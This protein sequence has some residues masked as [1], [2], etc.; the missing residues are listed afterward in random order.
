MNEQTDLSRGD[1]VDFRVG[2]WVVRPA[3]GVI[4]SAAGEV[5]L[6]PRVMQLLVYLAER[7]GT[8]VSA[9][10]LLIDVWRGAFYG[11]NPVH[12]CVAM[13]RRALADSAQSPRYLQTLR[14]RGY[15]LIAPVSLPQDH[16]PD[17]QQG[18][19]RPWRGECPFVGLRAFSSAE[20]ALYFGRSRA[21]AGLLAAVREQLR[22]GRNLLLV[23][24]PSG[25]GKSSLLRAGVLPRLCHAQGHDG[26]RVG[27]VSWIDLSR[28]ALDRDDCLAR[29]RA[30]REPGPPAGAPVTADALVIDHLET[31]ASAAT[32]EV[33]RQQ[34][35]ALLRELSEQPRLLLFLLA[36]SDAYSALLQTL[37][38]LLE[39][40]A[41]GGQ[42][43][44]PPVGRGEVAEMIRGPA[45]LA[46]LRFEVDPQTRVRLDDAL[47]DAAAGHPA[48]LPLL[49]YTLQQLYDRREPDGTL[50]FAAYRQIGGLT[51][52]IASRAEA[53]FQSLSPGIQAAL[54]GVLTKLVRLDAADDLLT[55][56]SVDRERLG[57]INE[58]AL[59][60]ALVDARLLTADHWQGRPTISLAHDALLREWPRAHA[61]AQDNRRLISARQRLAEAT[62]RWQ[63]AGEHPDHL[64]PDGAPL[65]QAQSVAAQIPAS[66]RREER[67]FLHL[68]SRRGRQRQRL[69]WGAVGALLL[70][71]I[72]AGVFAWDATRARQVAEQRRLEGET[73]VDFLLDDLS[74]RLR[75]IGRLDLLGSVTQQVT[76][77]L[78]QAGAPASAQQA[79]RRARALRNLAEVDAG[80]GQ[81]QTASEA[82]QAALRL[83][84]AVDPAE[85]DNDAYDLEAG[86][87]HY[88]HGFL[89]LQAADPIAAMAAWQAYHAAAE[90]M[91]QR[92][93]KSPLAQLELSYALNNLGNLALRER[94][95]D[96]AATKFERSIQL[97]R[98][99]HLREPGRND[100]AADL[101]DSLS[102]LASVREA[103]GQ[104]AAA[105]ALYEE[106][107]ALLRQV[108]ER[109]PEDQLWRYR[110]TTAITH[111]GL[112]Q[113]ARGQIEAARSALSESLRAL[114]QLSAGDPSNRAW[115]RDLAHVAMQLG[116]LE[117]LAGRDTAASVAVRQAKTQ[118]DDLLA[119]PEPLPD[120][121]RLRLQLQWRQLVIEH[122]GLST[123]QQRA[124][125]DSLV[126]QWQQLL[127]S[128]PEDDLTL[129]LAALLNVQARMPAD[130]DASE[131]TAAL[132]QARQLLQPRLAD[133]L[134][135]RALAL[136]VLTLEGL[137]QAD[138]TATQRQALLQMGYRH[139]ELDALRD[140]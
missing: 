47:R 68:S 15:R 24:G 17:W 113:L 86:T 42:F 37:P 85:R 83:L 20:F 131:R 137:D 82:I 26:L 11:D 119:L 31:V 12:K 4:S 105:I 138:L 70:S 123:A 95:L 102:W 6:E 16:D 90:R 64:L 36:R 1:P 77:Y 40:K 93:P 114:E 124:I 122:E 25:I 139:P 10:Q 35:D 50:S 136:W 127:P 19:A 54:P 91:L 45:R 134:D 129:E 5:T 120:W 63:Q 108:S 49:Q 65:L 2:E 111:A 30:D 21:I 55:G 29:L 32:S 69:R 99:L 132:Q 97:K 58:Q 59:V 92:D 79:L 44:V 104:L 18:L 72:A 14:K 88:W 62:D 125:S 39:L 130:R 46:G 103:Q 27:R 135:R 7:A 128:S 100:V 106:Q 84:Q 121:Q 117:F 43:D 73:L 34:I 3:E 41:G 56:R 9:D 66:L 112:L 38:S 57:D 67:R 81:L 101:A 126:E 53:V 23:L 87:V 78:D 33:Q 48:S 74:E 80:R 75:Q 110:L 116:W 140:L 98:S 96:D 118:I 22:E 51:G 76:R 60:A 71:T 133:T 94:H 8:V 52:A 109:A 61:W 89:A 13:L 107:Q 115:Q 28:G